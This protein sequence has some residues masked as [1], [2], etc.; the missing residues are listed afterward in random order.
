MLR[1]VLQT[2]GSNGSLESF[3][4]ER[5]PRSGTKPGSFYGASAIAFA[6]DGRL[7]AT[8]N[9]DHTVGLWDAEGNQLALLK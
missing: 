2:S 3:E 5:L 7:F 1:W 4:V 9:W 8:A 6:P